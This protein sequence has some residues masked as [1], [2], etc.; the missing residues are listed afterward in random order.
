MPIQLPYFGRNRNPSPSEHAERL[1]DVIHVGRL[2]IEAQRTSRFFKDMR[3]KKSYSD[4]LRQCHMT[5]GAGGNFKL[6]CLYREVGVDPINM[7]T[8]CDHAVPI[9]IIRDWIM[10]SSA[11]FEDMAFSPVALISKESDRIITKSGLAKKMPDGKSDQI[12]SRYFACEIEIQTHDGESVKEDW[13]WEDH[14][15]L[16]SKTNELKATISHLRGIKNDLFTTFPWD[17]PQISLRDPQSSRT[18]T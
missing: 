1:L 16:I 12:L 3:I 15:N 7:P 9:T 6:G 11:T 10:A 4:I 2:V 14:I 18:E 17:T 5:L 8:T 13:S